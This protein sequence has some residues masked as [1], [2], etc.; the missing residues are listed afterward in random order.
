MSCS[1]KNLNSSKNNFYRLIFGLESMLKSPGYILL[2]F[3]KLAGSL[4]TSLLSLSKHI[5]TENIT[6]RTVNF[7]Y[8]TLK[9]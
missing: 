3:K 6:Q 7:M 5:K 8:P 9:Q 1:N 2:D 4:K